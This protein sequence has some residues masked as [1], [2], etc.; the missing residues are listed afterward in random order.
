MY[1]FDL[2]AMDKVFYQREN[3]LVPAKISHDELAKIQSRPTGTLTDGNLLQAV[4]Y[5]N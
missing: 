5:S 1:S 3:S 4:P 2:Q